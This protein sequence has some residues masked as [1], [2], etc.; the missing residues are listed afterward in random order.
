MT[1]GAPL[2]RQVA[3]KTQEAESSNF[4]AFWSEGSL[5]FAPVSRWTASLTGSP[6]KAVAEGN[7]LLVDQGEAKVGF[8]HGIGT[9]AYWLRS[10]DNGEEKVLFWDLLAGLHIQYEVSEDLVPFVGGRWIR[11]GVVSKPESQVFRDTE[12][13][14]ISAGALVRTGPFGLVPELTMTNAWWEEAHWDVGEVAS[15]E[16]AQDSLWLVMLAVTVMTGF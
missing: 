2:V 11:G 16:M 5:L 9:S 1:L 13:I 12:Y 4:L 14:C 7:L 15:L 6:Y 3:S 8:L 10:P